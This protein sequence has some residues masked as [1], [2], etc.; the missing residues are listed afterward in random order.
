[1]VILVGVVY[2]LAVKESYLV[3]YPFVPVGRCKEVPL[4]LCSKVAPGTFV[5]AVAVAYRG[6]FHCGLRV[7]A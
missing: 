7:G 3:M 2:S 4:Y 1:M 6:D 5:L